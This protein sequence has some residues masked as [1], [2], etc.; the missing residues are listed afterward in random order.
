MKNF[1]SKCP[2]HAIATL[3]LLVHAGVLTEGGKAAEE[4]PPSASAPGVLDCFLST[5]DHHWMAGALPLDSPA[6]IAAS[7]DL[8]KAIGVRRIYWRG[9]QEAAMLGTAHIREENFRYATFAKWSRHLVEDL[10]IERLAVA[11]AHERGMELWGVGTLGDWGCTADTPGFNDYPWFW[12][13]TLRLEHPEWKPVDKYGY[14]RQGGPVELSYPEART[15]LVDLHARLAE[16][17]GYDG[18]CWLTYVENFSM[19]FQDEFAFNEPIVRDFQRKHGIDP[20]IDPFT[21]SACRT[22]FHKHRGTYLTDFLR[23]LKAALPA[24]AGLGMFLNPREPHY[25]QVWSTL[26]Q[27]FH[28]LGQIYFD[29]ETWVSEGIVDQLNVWGAYN[30]IGQPKTISDVLWLTRASGTAVGYLTS[31]PPAA[32]YE[33]FHGRAAALLAISD[34]HHYLTRS[35]LPEPRPS[36]LADGGVLEQMQILALVAEGKAT[37]PADAV[38][39]LARHENPVMRRLALGALAALKDISTLTALE[40]ALFDPENC[41][42]SMAML[43]LR[44]FNRPE[45]A[46]RMLAALDEHHEHPLHEAARDSL[47]RIQPAPRDALRVAAEH[48]D[49]VVRTTALRALRLIGPA[50]GDVPLLGARLDDPHRYAAY[51]AAETLGSVSGSEAA[52]RALIEATRHTDVAVADRAA[53]SLAEM[54]A[55]GDRSAKKLE[56]EILAAGRALFVQFGDGCARADADW[57]YRP[58]GEL[59]LALGA[60]GGAA[61]RECMDQNADRRL[62]ELAWRVLYFREKAGPNEF[63]FIS[64]AESD[65]A[66]QIRPAWLPRLRTSRLASG[67]DSADSFPADLT[68]M[69]GDSGRTGGRWGNFGQPGPSIDGD[70]AHSAPHSVRLG[71]AGRPLHGYITQ[72]ISDGRDWEAELWLR[73]EE[74]A[75]LRL[76]VKG[77]TPSVAPEAEA[78][79]T[80]DGEVRL[81]DMA[82][83]QW[84]DA[85]LRV[86]PGAWTR[87]R[88]IARRAYGDCYATVQAESGEERISDRRVPLTVRTDLYLVELSASGDGAVHADDVALLERL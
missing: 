71:P 72:D 70:V 58:V 45:S 23:E 10:D 65:A 42:R 69:T 14:R 13:S 35:G 59:L 54:I 22:D 73:C 61:L 12:E 49:E 75:G 29:L 53:T 25:P 26:P 33:P 2:I 85:G 7:F 82:T 74:G 55:R 68:G 79:V 11:A 64:E 78:V 86:E 39:R 88:L 16:H 40:D 19:R 28:T 66:F 47:A 63:R 46:A 21:K 41:V 6:S 52:V 67:F 38:A 31:S 18:V 62:A 77:R 44:S 76:A 9:L 48:E 57:G 37:V 4:S 56:A 3:I 51:S 50:E 20:R 83:E 27:D 80:E 43:A 15:A 8:L 36:A 30:A 84:I 24:G 81:R 87:L 5:G 1:H 32:I 17:A 60:S 34:D